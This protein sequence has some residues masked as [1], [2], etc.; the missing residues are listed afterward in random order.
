M[1][2]PCHLTGGTEEN[3]KNP[4]RKLI[5]PEFQSIN[6]RIQRAA[7]NSTVIFGEGFIKTESGVLKFHT[8]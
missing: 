8:K 4:V 7:T 2:Q 1:V 6:S 3:H 5:R